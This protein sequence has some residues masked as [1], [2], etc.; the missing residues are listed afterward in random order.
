MPG[1]TTTFLRQRLQPELAGTSCHGDVVSY[2]LAGSPVWL[3]LESM[4]AAGLSLSW[5]SDA[6][7]ESTSLDQLLAEAAQAAIASDGLTFLPFL[8]GPRS[9]AAGEFG[10]YFCKVNVRHRRQD[11]V[12]AIVEG[13]SFE[14]RRMAE[15]LHGGTLSQKNLPVGGGGGRSQFWARTLAS[16]LGTTVASS[17]RDSIQPLARLCLQVPRGT[18]GRCRIWPMMFVAVRPNRTLP[19]QRYIRR[20]TRPTLGGVEN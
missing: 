20:G 1:G 16:I 17:S 3:G 6:L 5:F 18:G 13:V 14:M 2:F 8:T 15:E 19:T 9:A 12:R 4:H 11:F 7:A 10:A